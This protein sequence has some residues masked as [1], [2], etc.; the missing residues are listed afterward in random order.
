MHTASL[1]EE[2][3]MCVADRERLPPEGVL[4]LSA[5]WHAHMCWWRCVQVQTTRFDQ[6]LATLGEKRRVALALPHWGVAQGVIAGTDLILTVARRSLSCD[7]LDPRLH[8]FE[9]PLAI[10]AFEFQQAWHE[11]R[12]GDAAHRWLRTCVVDVCRSTY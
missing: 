2:T 6:A 5:W 10:K 4:S 7:T 3:F 12:E 8:I 1:F 9:P 11:R